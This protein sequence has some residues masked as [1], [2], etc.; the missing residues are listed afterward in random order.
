[1]AKNKKSKTTSIG[2][3]AVIE[4]V[5][6]RGKTAEAVAVRAESGEILLETT[7][8][9]NADK[10]YY[11]IPIVRGVVS[12]F[13]SLVGGTKTLMR[14]ASVFG[15][16]ET[17]EFENWLSKKLKINAN[18]LVT[19]LGVF[20]GL[21]LSI[22]LFFFLPQLI[23]D[24]FTFIEPNGFL[25]CLIEGLIR[26]AI[27]IAYVMLTSLI[28]DIK[29]TYM[30][31]GAE[32]KTISCYENGLELTVENV[33]KCSR[34]HDRCG[35]TFMFLVMTVS[36][37]LF[38]V[39][40][41]VLSHFGVTFEGFTGKLL[42]FLLKLAVLPL[43][44]GV[45]YEILKLLAMSKSPVLIIFKAP[46]LLL[47]RITT[48]EPTSDM[49]EVAITAF[50]KVLEMDADQTVN[51]VKFNVF[52]TVKTLLNKVN[53]VLEK[54]KCDCESDGE[55]IVSRVTGVKRSNLSNS[56][57]T[58][59]KEQSDTALKYAKERSSG[60]P[61]AY[62]FGD[63]DF[64][65]L[66]FK[67]N[68]SVLI[69]R[70]ETEELVM[71]SLKV[72]NAS[73]LVLD[74]CTGSGAIAVTI[75]AKTG[76]KVIAVDYYDNALDIAK[77]NAKLN[78]VSVN[79]IKSNMFDSVTEKFNVIISNPPYI[80]SEDLSSLQNEVKL[81]PI[82]ALDG[83]SDGLDFYKILVTCSHKHLLDN[84]YLFLECGIGQ[85]SEIVNL[86]NAQNEYTEIEIIKD[87]NG[88]DRIIKARK[89]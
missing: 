72:I 24:L 28:K 60:V 55:W 16:D 43:I 7:R 33:K 58:V 66:T 89:K 78:G 70:P 1:M 19:F 44:A 12:F 11:K 17:S 5:M 88:V 27:F 2:G 50:N 76:A 57:L 46:G 85:A 53:S 84:G 71:H 29:R 52:G 82:T 81:E 56:T 32:H 14:S 9:K 25:Y 62:V 73:D 75:G 30:Y 34:V 4:G 83:G 31:H 23:A 45:S 8:L 87:I 42:R 80:K 68:E 61:L 10:P 69:P 79:F 63:A 20:L 13:N 3:Q 65:G 49:I 37:L 59:T 36:I 18:D 48:S 64:Y 47:Q 51:E 26:I 39:L 15:E 67:V 41:A 38:A 40:N 74:M 22:L 6:M 21:A 54:S 35:T 77:E 86:L